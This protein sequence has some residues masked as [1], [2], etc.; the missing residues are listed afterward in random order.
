MI[1]FL[2]TDCV[3]GCS[4]PSAYKVFFVLFFNSN[5]MFWVSLYCVFRYVPCGG[6]T[7]GTSMSWPPNT[8]PWP[9]L[10]WRGGQSA[11]GSL[12]LWWTTSTTW[13][14]WIT[15][16]RWSATCLSTGRLSSGGG[17]FLFIWSLW[18]W[19]RLTASS[20][21]T[22]TVVTVA[23][24]SLSSLPWQ[25]VLLLQTVPGQKWR[26]QQGLLHKLGMQATGWLTGTSLSPSH[27]HLARRGSNCLVSCATQRASV[28]VV[29]QARWRPK[30]PEHRWCV[31]PARQLCVCILASKCTTQRKITVPELEHLTVRP[32][33]LCQ[34]CTSQWCNAVVNHSMFIILQIVLIFL[35]F[36]VF[37]YEVN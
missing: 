11:R 7:S 3:Y 30:S 37:F 16:T 23:P 8:T 2:S 13:Q 5:S 14:E 20:I 31:E 21:K 24:W 26:L 25:S 35:L 27:P 12:L 29:Q 19:S 34:C 15:V 18:Q 6:R 10:R 17:N 9:W 32:S 28:R 33:T 1:F 4:T 36:F 22:S